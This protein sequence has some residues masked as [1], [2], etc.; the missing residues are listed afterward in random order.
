M[1]GKSDIEKIRRSLIKWLRTHLTGNKWPHA[2]IGRRASIIGRRGTIL[3][4]IDAIVSDG[5]VVSTEEGGEIVMGERCE[6]HR[7]AL[8]LSYGGRIQIGNDCSVNPY[9]ILYG[10]GGLTLGNG[11]RIAAHT[12]IIPANHRFDDITR[13]IRQQPLSKKGI[14]IEDDVWIGAGARIL[15]GVVIHKGA[16]IGAGAVVTRDVPAFTVNAGVPCRVIADRR[17]GTL[18][19]ESNT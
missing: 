17:P 1:N 4:G 3:L 14:T 9:S 19:H 2:V 8:L 11:V 12:V 15:D 13:P 6:I 10:H 18:I 5:A 16:I 7:G